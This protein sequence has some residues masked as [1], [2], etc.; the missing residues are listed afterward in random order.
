[1]AVSINTTELKTVLEITP[2]SHNIMLV[3]KHGIGKSR[4]ITDY[5]EALGRKVVTL[6][7]GQMSDPGDIIGLPALDRNTAAQSAKGGGRTIF[8]PPWWFPLGNKP[9]VLFLDELNRARPEILQCI[10]DLALNKSIAGRSLPAGSQIISAVNEGEEYQLTD[11]DPA[12]VSRFNVYRFEPTSAEWL[13]WAAE[14]KLDKRVIDFISANPDCLDSDG[15]ENRAEGSGL[16]KGPDRRSWERVSE[17]VERGGPIDRTMEKIIAGIVGN[18]AAL[19]FARFARNK[20]GFDPLLVLRNFNK[21]KPALEKLPVHELSAV[22]EGLFRALELE[23]NEDT[24]KKYIANLELYI[25]WLQ[26]TKRSEVLA[27]WTTLF[28]SSSYPQAKV[29]IM[30]NSH[31]IFDNM[32][33]FIQ[34]L[35]V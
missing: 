25:K 12:L 16:D 35:K 2:A 29:A 4:I 3:G 5:F 18:S 30:S 23:Q 24:L 11:L 27:H 10:M 31:Y 7:L 9:I 33:N 32:V 17:I 21:A 19:R 34:N 20:Q 22:N 1:M 6:F 14:K 26:K 13:L 8:Y 15:S 28:D